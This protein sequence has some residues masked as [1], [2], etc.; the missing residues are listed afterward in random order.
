LSYLERKT[1]RPKPSRSRAL[2][3]VGRCFSP[4][5]ARIKRGHF[6]GFLFPAPS[7]RAAS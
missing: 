2:P 5:L 6:N 4:C 7:G 3:R 1:A